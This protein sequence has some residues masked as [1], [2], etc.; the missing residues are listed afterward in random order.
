MPHRLARVLTMVLQAASAMPLPICMR[1]RAE[2]RI[3]HALGVGGKVVHSPL[4]DTARLPWLRWN[5]RQR[6]D[7]GDER[8]TVPL[9]QQRAG[10]CGPGRSPCCAASKDRMGYVPHVFFGMIEIKDLHRPCKVFGSQL[11]D[12]WRA[13]AQHDYL[14]GLL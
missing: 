3:A 9:F 11:P 12:P 5:G 10:V 1:L 2:E 13:I 8:F 4:W 6:L 14:L 7:R